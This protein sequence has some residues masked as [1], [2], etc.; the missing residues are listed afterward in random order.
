MKSLRSITTFLAGALIFSSCVKKSF[1]NPP[2]ASAYDPALPTNAHIA[3][4]SSNA[5]FNISV[6]KGRVLGDTT[7]SGIV[8]GDDHSGNLYKQIII[9][10]S[11]SGLV[12]LM[13]KTYLYG[14]YPVGRRVYV[15]LNGLYLVNY[16]GVPE[17][18]YSIDSTGYTSGIPSAL[19]SNYLVKGSYPHFVTP[20]TISNITDLLVSNPVYAV[21]TLISIDS[22][23]FAAASAGVPYASTVSSTSRYIFQCIGGVANG[24]V[25]VYNSSY[26]SFQPYLTPTGKGSLTCIYSVYNNTPQLLLRDTTDVK[27][28]DPRVC[29]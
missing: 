2:D 26:A 28:N 16:K 5:L 19:I 4:L 21:N 12:I 27:L 25:A 6:G 7:I 18:A 20:R 8:V 23:E 17:I 24:S 10:D 15:K 14:D 11:A 1:D 9:Q 3:D 13:D 29:P 22:V